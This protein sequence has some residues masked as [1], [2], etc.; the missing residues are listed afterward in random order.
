MVSV[1]QCDVVFVVICVVSSHMDL[2]CFIF[3]LCGLVILILIPL[4]L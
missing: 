1:I 4:I 2:I 3:I